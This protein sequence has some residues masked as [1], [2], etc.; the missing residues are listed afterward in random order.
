MLK[1]KSALVLTG[2]VLHRGKHSALKPKLQAQ[3]NAENRNRKM[4]FPWATRPR[5][6][7]WL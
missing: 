5:T 1:L 3:S 7:W 6:P 4:R 2:L